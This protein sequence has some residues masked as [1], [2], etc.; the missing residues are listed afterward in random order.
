MDGDQDFLDSWTK[1]KDGDETKY[2]DLFGK[3]IVGEIVSVYSIMDCSEI[4]KIYNALEKQRVDVFYVIRNPFFRDVS[5]II[6][7]MHRQKKRLDPCS[8]KECRDFV[9]TTAFLQRS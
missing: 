3:K 1:T 9:D 8:L 4:T 5:Q 2:L 6:F 7:A